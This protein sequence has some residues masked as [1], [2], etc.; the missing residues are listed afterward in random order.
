MSKNENE[1]KNGNKSKNENEK[2]N[3]NENKNKSKKWKSKWKQ[4]LKFIFIFIFGFFFLFLFLFPCFVFIFASF[5]RQRL[6]VSKSFLPILEFPI[7]FFW[8]LPKPKSNLLDLGILVHGLRMANL[9][10]EYKTIFLGKRGKPWNSS[11]NFSLGWIC[12]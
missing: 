4:K 6:K 2:K 1:N 10:D 9:V 3:K 8:S 11:K 5:S 12:L 7:N